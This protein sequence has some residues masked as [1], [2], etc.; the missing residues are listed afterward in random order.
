MVVDPTYNAVTEDDRKTKSVN[1]VKVCEE[2]CLQP[3]DA[4]VLLESSREEETAASSTNPENNNKDRGQRPTAEKYNF[5]T[6]LFFLTHKAY[7]LGYSVTIERLG[8]IT[9][10]LHNVQS[11]YLDMYNANPESDFVKNIH[12]MLKEQTQQYLCIRNCLLEPE[13]DMGILKLF[14]A[15]AIWLSELSLISSDEYREM[16]KEKNFA[17]KTRRDRKLPSQLKDVPE[18]LRCVPEKIVDN[19]IT[20]LNFIR[21]LPPGQNI[22]LY[23]SSHDAFFNM[24][25]HFMGSSKLASNPHTRAK[26]AEAMEF[27]VPKRPNGET[28]PTDVIDV[29]ANRWKLVPSLINVFVTIEMTGQ[30]VQF[31]QK[32]NYRRPM[33]AIME[34]L[35]TKEEYVQFFRDMAIEA[36]TNMEA[37]E[38][39]LFLRFINLLINDAI[40]LLGEYQSAN[41]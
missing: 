38:P 14:E 41:H 35:W 32:F 26:L 18:L 25:V 5:I 22:Q 29:H 37:I 24:I 19:L 7:E 20:Y 30:S 13:N 11:A 23:T 8:K 4:D 16:L 34:Y 21:L 27:F 40:F 3:L 39:P 10:E 33:Y 12:R 28:F 6:E 1:M 9:R 36:E 17:P 31:E 15:T 2:T